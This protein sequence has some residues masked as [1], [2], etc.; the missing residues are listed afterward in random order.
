MKFNTIIDFYVNQVD[1]YEGIHFWNRNDSK[2]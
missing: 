2:G 1:V